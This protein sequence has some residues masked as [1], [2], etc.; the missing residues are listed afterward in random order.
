[1]GAF[2]C[3]IWGVLAVRLVSKSQRLKATAAVLGGVAAAGEMEADALTLS[4][5]R[6]EEIVK[7]AW[8]EVDE[9]PASDDDNVTESHANKEQ[10]QKGWDDLS[11]EER[12][13]INRA[14]LN[15]RKLAEKSKKWWE[16]YR[17]ALKMERE[18][19]CGPAVAIDSQ[20]EDDKVALDAFQGGYTMMALQRGRFKHPNGRQLKAYSC[21]PSANVQ[22]PNSDTFHREIK[23]TF[24]DSST[25]IPV[26]RWN[27]LKKHE[28]MKDAF[29]PHGDDKHW[30]V[31]RIGIE[32]EKEKEKKEKQKFAEYFFENVVNR[33]PKASVHSLSY[34]GVP[35]KASDVGDFVGEMA[36]GS[37]T[38]CL[39]RRRSARLSQVAKAK[40]PKRVYKRRAVEKESGLMTH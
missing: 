39:G 17:E 31:A 20:P 37:I 25:I 35:H 7:E 38:D 10:G 27:K 4:V 9:F 23:V 15:A 28:E 18:E 8:M 13:Q 36:T 21:V 29:H 40:T 1:M 32:Q 12:I 14:E 30:Q 34:R 19:N 33:I 3:G 16:D 22:S 2:T 26:P 5:P 6:S 11:I 24:C